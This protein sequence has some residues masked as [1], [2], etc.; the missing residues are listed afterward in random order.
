MF[1]PSCL[2]HH[3]QAPSVAIE[4][5]LSGLCRRGGFGEAKVQSRGT[6][7]AVFV[8]ELLIRRASEAR[9]RRE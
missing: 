6:Y 5:G 7:K 2:A 8:D 4:K 3:L 9:G 1:L